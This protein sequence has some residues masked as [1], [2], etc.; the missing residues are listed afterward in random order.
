MLVPSKIKQISSLKK[1]PYYRDD[2]CIYVPTLDGEEVLFAIVADAIN[3]YVKC[4]VKD[5]N[6]HFKVD[7]TRPDQLQVVRRK[8]NVVIFVEKETA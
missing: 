2:H 7:P 8:G 4:Y 6:G 1:H 3:G 5:A